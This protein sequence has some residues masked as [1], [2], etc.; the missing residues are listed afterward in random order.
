MTTILG[1]D[2][3]THRLG[4]GVV[5][6]S[7]SKQS[8]IASGCIENKPGTTPDIYLPKIH[9]EISSIIAEYNPDLIGLESLLFQKN[10][11]TA[12][13]VAEA[14]G[15]IRLIAGSHNLSVIESAPN[16]IKLSV[17]G[18]GSASKFEVIRMVGLLL[19][20]KISQ[21]RDDELDALA[22][23]ISTIVTNKNL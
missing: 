2:P 20:I 15:V 6:G 19:G 14:R 23:A 21:K 8:F 3:G 4:W 22:V 5:S 10:V 7:P 18:S 9:Q 16:T 11:K 1:I 13:P 12:I 17:A